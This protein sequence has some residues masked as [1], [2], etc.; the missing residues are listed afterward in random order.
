MERSQCAPIPLRTGYDVHMRMDRILHPTDFS[1]ASDEALERA[2]G[3]AM[4]HGAA[5]TVF[6][7]E[8]V[9]HDQAAVAAKRERVDAIVAALVSA[10]RPRTGFELIH[11]SGSEATPYAGI[12]AEIRRGSPD[13]VVMA[14][15]G[16]GIVTE[17]VAESIVRDAPCSVLTCRRAGRGRWP[18]EPGSV[19]VAVDFSESAKRALDVAKALACPQSPLTVVHV[20]DV[21]RHPSLYD[22]AIPTPFEADPELQAR[23]E[24]HLEQWAGGGIERAVAVQGDVRTALGELC[25]AQESVLVVVGTHGLHDEVDYPLGSTAE[26]LT[27]SALAP[28][29]T[30]R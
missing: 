19:L 7:T 1:L 30:V 27:R 6:H 28:V 15:H 9:G 4:A 21:P 11:Q 22:R 12:I 5:L 26:R 18:L 14:T 8:R 13:L 17:S 24:Q 3:L 25:R 2:V 20:V 10:G 16:G 23:I 29:L